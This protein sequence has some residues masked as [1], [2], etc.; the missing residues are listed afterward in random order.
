MKKFFLVFFLLINSFI[1]QGI[2]IERTPKKIV[3]K[4]EYVVAFDPMEPPLQFVEEGVIKGFNIELLNLIGQK[5]NIKFIY[6]PMTKK[7]AY[8]K[9]VNKK[10]DAVIG[11]RF[12]KEYEN[13]IRYTDSIGEYSVCIVAPKTK[14]KS[15]KEGFG[16]EDF[17]VGVEK[18]SSEYNYLKNMKKVNFNIVFDQESLFKLL[19]LERADFA[20]GVQEIAEYIMLEKNLYNKYETM[21]S[22]TAPVS[23]YIGVSYE[24]ESLVKVINGELKNLKINGSYE[25]LFVKWNKSAELEKEK[26]MLQNIKTISYVSLILVLILLVIS[27]WNIQLKKIVKDKT[28]KL[29]KINKELEEKIIEIR[30][31]N[32]LNSIICE[33]SPRCI[34]IFD[35]DRKITFMNKNSINLFNAGDNFKGKDAYFYPIMEKIIGNGVFEKTVFENEAHITRELKINLN[36]R[37]EYFRYT[38]YPLLDYQK[39]NIGAFLTMEECTKEKI[40]REKSLKKEKDT[41]IA[42]IIAGI[43]HE[44]RNP[45]TA[46]KTYIELLPLKKDNE[47]FREQIVTIVPKEVERV[48]RLIENL[49]DYI[50]PKANSISEINLYDII[51]SSML[52]LKPT[53]DK[54]SIKIELDIDTTLSIKGDPAQI[55]QVLINIL[56]NSIDAINEKKEKIDE[57]EDYFIKIKNYAFE[58]HRI[59]EITDNGIGMTEK[60]LKNIY[61]VFYTTKAKGT[62][63]GLPLT[64]QLIEKNNGNLF[65]ESEKNK[66]TKFTIIF[67]VI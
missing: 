2:S 43:A 42:T 3:L 21:N 67:E 39:N 50:K 40:L 49:I 5:N 51:N 55:K 33:S 29:R 20:I 66:F 16:N 12:D 7:E 44:I 14:I 19:E 30:N 58:E 37:E 8:E 24:N 23:Y 6:V 60:E 25:N 11:M 10:I 18:G 54:N 57:K 13:K 56:L 22:Y 62:G 32:E 65:V 41:A 45:M 35:R 15:I 64:K 61:E 38:L 31:N 63:L 9:L 52:L 59:I 48:N 47:K 27:I 4:K 1:S 46:I 17:I 26:Q 34:T 53:F 28:A 36:G